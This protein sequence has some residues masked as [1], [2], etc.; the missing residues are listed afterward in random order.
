MSDSVR[1]RLVEELKAV[2]G[3][4]VHVIPYQDSVDTLD[5]RTV[6]VKQQ[7]ITRLPEAPTSKLRID[8]VLTFISPALDP[9]AA[10][11]DLDQWVPQTLSDLDMSWFAWT[12]AEKVLFD[13]LNTAYDVSSYVLTTSTN[14]EE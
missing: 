13:P 2:L 11:A 4:D 10:E 3:K 6:M 9:E 1:D 12:S 14:E 7:T 8:Y 5:R